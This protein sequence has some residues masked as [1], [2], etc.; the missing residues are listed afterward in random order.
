MEMKETDQIVMYGTTWCGDCRRCRSI[1]DQ[2][3]IP[4]QWV[5][6]DQDDEAAKLVE[7]MNRGYRSIPTI[8]WPDGSHLTEPSQDELADK[9]GI[10]L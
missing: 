2:H 3:S 7:N 10:T 9:L 5:D 4:Y 6:I 8:V 1:L